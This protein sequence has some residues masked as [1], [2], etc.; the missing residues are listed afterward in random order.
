[1]VTHRNLEL[2]PGKISGIKKGR[3]CECW[4]GNMELV[5]LVGRTEELRSEL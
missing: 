5:R 4:L 1:M 3:V 2:G